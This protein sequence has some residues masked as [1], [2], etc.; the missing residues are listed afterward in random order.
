M[1]TVCILPRDM[2][3]GAVI[4]WHDGAYVLARFRS[5]NI[6]FKTQ[7][8]QLGRIFLTDNRKQALISFYFKQELCDQNIRTIIYEVYNFLDSDIRT[9]Q[10]N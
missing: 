9:K 6:W 8:T 4:M 2:H 10:Y 7:T 3:A 5:A 1:S